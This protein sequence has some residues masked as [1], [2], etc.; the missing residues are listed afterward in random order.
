MKPDD[1]HR[2]VRARMVA[3]LDQKIE[4]QVDELVAD[5]RAGGVNAA[6][7]SPRVAALRR[8]LAD[9]RSAELNTIEAQLDA[10]FSVPTT[11]TRVP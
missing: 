3:A 11:R 4:R 6:A 9:W 8:Q 1:V 2:A 5:L 7:R 10:Q